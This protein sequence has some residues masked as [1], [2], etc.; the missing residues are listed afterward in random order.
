MS[1]HEKKKS[2]AVAPGKLILSGEHAVVYGHPALVMAVDRYVMT[3]VS[4]HGKPEMIVAGHLITLSELMQ[5][6]KRIRE[7]YHKFVKG[8]LTIKE[9]LQTP[10]ELVQF[11]LSLLIDAINGSSFSG[12][13]VSIQADL[14]I[15][16]GMGSSAAVVLSVL[17]A[18]AHYLQIPLSPESL[19]DLAHQAETMQH[20]KSSGL[21]LRSSLQGGCLFFQENQTQSRAS[22]SQAFYLINTGQPQTTTGECIAAAAS[23]FKNTSIG[24]DFAAVTQAI[25]HALQ[26]NKQDEVMAGMREN[27]KLLNTIGVVPD[28]VQQLIAEIEYA[29][30]AAKI[31]GAGAVAGDRAGVVLIAI[32]DDAMLKKIG[33]RYQHTILPIQCVARG[34]YVHDLV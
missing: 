11:A 31:S 20:G 14:F 30:G 25:D 27:H 5:L 23:Y 28:K 13:Q 34:M 24:D 22:S 33:S 9:V 21:D 3:T 32:E 17:A 8:H 4:F 26:R 7:D 29:G 16:C 10:L 19:F 6:Q 12:F 2:Q 18:A 15:G 1:E